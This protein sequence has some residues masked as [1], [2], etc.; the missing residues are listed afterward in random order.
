MNE[1]QDEIKP[2]RNISKPSGV[3]FS[4]EEIEIVFDEIVNEIALTNKSLRD[5]LTENINYP[6]ANTFFKWMIKDNEKAQRY[7]H[8][9]AVKAHLLFNDL[10]AISKGDGIDDTVVKVQR[11]RLITDSL[12]FFIAKVL[13]KVYGDKID[14]TSEGKAVVVVNLGTGIA[15][16]EATEPE[17]L[18]VTE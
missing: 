1:H 15:P 11:D 16:P 7:A 5:I 13:P 12:K 2:K 4:K 17:Y 14:I 3:Q 6:N 10:L 18:D 9:Q 8:A